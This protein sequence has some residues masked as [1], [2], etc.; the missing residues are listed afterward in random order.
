[1]M[2]PARPH[3]R[4]L[5]LVTSN[6]V[7][8]GGMQKFTRDLVRATLASGWRVTVALSGEDIYTED[9]GASAPRLSVAKVDWVDAGMAGDRRFTWKAV[10]DR[11][12]WFRRARAD[13]AL[14]VQ[15]S[16]TP[17][18]AAVAG[19]YLAR[20]PVVTTHRTM[21]AV[22]PHVPS[23]RHLFGLLR[24]VGLH[25]RLLVLKTWLTAAMARTVV[26]NSHA[27]CRGYEAD[28]RYPRRKGCVIPNAVQMESVPPAPACEQVRIGFVGRLGYEK[29]VDILLRAVASLKSSRPVQVAIHGDGP[30]RAS[31]QQLA[32]ELGIADRVAWCGVTNDLPAA[33]AHLDIVALCSPRES[34]SNMVLEAMAAGKAVVVSRVGGLPE[35][36]GYSRGGLCVPAEDVAALASAL[37]RLV[38]DESLRSS[39]GEAARESARTRH[40]PGRIA[41]SWH[42]VLARA[43]GSSQQAPAA[44]TVIDFI[45]PKSAAGLQAGG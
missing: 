1:M 34:S 19:A 10:W 45:P 28:Y 35:L 32:G 14:F 3:S 44:E 4:H 36:V 12:R 27:V 30:E 39:L 9:A 5:V 42:D 29:R 33:Y 22:I 16:N 15:S 26:Y 38:E 41:A 2:S 43:A 37:R 23:R 7:R 40:H 11:Y 24:G 31:L 13:V 17:F 6:P 21:P 20:V 8:T 18:R 25:R